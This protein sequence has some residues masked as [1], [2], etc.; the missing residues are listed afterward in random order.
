MHAAKNKIVS[1]LKKKKKWYTNSLDEHRREWD[2]MLLRIL[3][4]YS[5]FLRSQSIYILKYYQ[6]FL[7]PLSSHGDNIVEMEIMSMVLHI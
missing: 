1:Y 7:L 3:R 6:E 4:T 2:G 5:E